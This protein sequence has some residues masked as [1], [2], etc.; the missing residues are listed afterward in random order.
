MA[1]IKF[2][3]LLTNISGSVGGS[4]FQVN[5]YGWS[6]KNKQ[7]GVNPNSSQQ[8]FTKASMRV[9]LSAWTNLSDADRKSWVDYA[10]A[11]KITTKFDSGIALSGFNLFL[12]YNLLYQ[13]SNHNLADIFNSVTLYKPAVD[14]ADISLTGS[15]TSE[16]LL[17]TTWSVS[18]NAWFVNYYFTKPLPASV[19]FFKTNTKFVIRA[20]NV[21]GSLDFTGEYISTFGSLPPAGSWIGLKYILFS[22]SGGFVCRPLYVKLKYN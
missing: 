1:R 6:L 18:D 2:G 22:S 4:T 19:N 21:D 15:G 11:F 10:A 20:N 12:K 8:N 16:M 14:G 5:R 9:L 13:L 17:N 3:A 7:S